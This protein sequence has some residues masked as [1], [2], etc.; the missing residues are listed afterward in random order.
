M[1]DRA[2]TNDLLLYL[3]ENHYILKSLRHY[4]ALVQFW[5]IQLLGLRQSFFVGGLVLRTT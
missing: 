4:L 2:P 1:I 3:I 5:F